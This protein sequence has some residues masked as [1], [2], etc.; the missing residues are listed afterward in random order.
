MVLRGIN[1]ENLQTETTIYIHDCIYTS[2]SIFLIFYFSKKSISEFPLFSIK[3]INM[4][5]NEIINIIKIISY[6]FINKLT[7]KVTLR[8]LEN[9]AKSALRVQ[10]ACI[11]LRT[12]ASYLFTYYNIYLKKWASKWKNDGTTL[13]KKLQLWKAKNFVE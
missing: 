3:P 7:F 8:Y 1:Y 5:P 12:W 4:K 9:D 2:E 6:I 11:K 13:V 10:N